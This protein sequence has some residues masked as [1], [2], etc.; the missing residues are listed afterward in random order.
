M[1]R[2]EAIK[3]AVAC[4]IP[5]LAPNSPDKTPPLKGV[6]VFYYPEGST[7]CDGVQRENQAVAAEI[8]G[9]IGEGIIFGA[10]FVR[11]KLP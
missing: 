9:K 1:N 8:A 6:G 10:N 7:E 4:L 3:S 5:S 11:E 2:R